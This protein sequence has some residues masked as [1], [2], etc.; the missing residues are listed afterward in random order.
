VELAAP[1]RTRAADAPACAYGQIIWTVATLVVCDGQGTFKA[2]FFA[3][4]IAKTV[5]VA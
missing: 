3:R 2:F 5:S 4:A 1:R